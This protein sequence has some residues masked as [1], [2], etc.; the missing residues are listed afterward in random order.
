MWKGGRRGSFMMEG[1]CTNIAK[2]HWTLKSGNVEDLNTPASYRF[3]APSIGGSKILRDID[4]QHVYGMP[5]KWWDTRA[6]NWR[7]NCYQPLGLVSSRNLCL[8][9]ELNPDLPSKFIDQISAGNEI[10]NHRATTDRGN[11]REHCSNCSCWSLNL[12]GRKFFSKTVKEAFVAVSFLWL[13]YPE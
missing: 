1:W 6:I 11:T 5:C 3:T 10:W 2:D 7:K 13:T 12:H 9:H 4:I 8:K